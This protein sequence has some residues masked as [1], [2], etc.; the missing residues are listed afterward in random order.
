MNMLW[1]FESSRVSIHF[2]VIQSSSNRYQR[3]FISYE[4][5]SCLAS[6]I[7]IHEAVYYHFTKIESGKS[8]FSLGSSV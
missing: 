7:N 4:T 3:Y 6:L 2:I 5:Y 8:Y 1:Y